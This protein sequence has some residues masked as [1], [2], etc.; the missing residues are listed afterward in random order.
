MGD[1]LLVVLN[2]K[3]F[4]ATLEYEKAGNVADNV[5]MGLT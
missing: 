1:R 3:V 5:G 2:S 4:L